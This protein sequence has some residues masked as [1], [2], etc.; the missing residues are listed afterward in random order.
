[1]RIELGDGKSVEVTT[2][3]Y[4]DMLEDDYKWNRFML[5]ARGTEINDPFHNSRLKIG[6]ESL[7]DLD[8]ED[9]FIE[10]EDFSEF[11]PDYD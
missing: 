11:M 4:L 8:S 6:D 5:L 1:M 10:D 9:I 7:L 2:E 3:Q